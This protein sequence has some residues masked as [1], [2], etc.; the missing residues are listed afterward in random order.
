MTDEMKQ[1]IQK[2]KKDMADVRATERS[3][4]VALTR[5]EGKVDGISDRLEKEMA[6]KTQVGTLIDKVDDF[7]EIVE[8]SRGERKIFDESFRAIRG[9]LQDH[10]ARL[11]RL[12]PKKSV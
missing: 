4:A 7:C 3:I 8:A 2:L 12:E 9:T 10:E 5:I 11:V 6:T 1:D